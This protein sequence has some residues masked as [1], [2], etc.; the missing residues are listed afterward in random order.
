MVTIRHERSTDIAARER[1]LDAALGPS[2]F[3]KPS[4]RLRE[5]RF[6]ADGLSLVAVEGGRLVGTV[7]LWNVAA[8][9]GRP[10]LLLGPLAVT[11]G[12]RNRGVGTKLMERALREARR[13]GHR[14]VLLVGDAIYYERFGFAAVRARDLRLKGPYEQERLIGLELMAGALNGAR[15]LIRATGEYIPRDLPAFIVHPGHANRVLPRA[16]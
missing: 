7:R 16:A 14:A 2:R 10:A 1:L 4:E 3:A 8:G 13:L 5:G 11:A 6:A 9:R 15:G 12:A